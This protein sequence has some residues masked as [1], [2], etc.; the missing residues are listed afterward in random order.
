[1]QKEGKLMYIGYAR[2]ST[3]D[4]SLD[5]QKDALNAARCELIY[6]DVASGTNAE[7]LRMKIALEYMRS[8][9]VRIVLNLDRLGRSLVD[10]VS[11]INRLNAEGKGF[12]CLDQSFDTTT[13]QGKLIFQL[14]AA[15]AEF[16]RNIIRERTMA[17]L[18]AARARGHL[19]GRKPK[20]TLDDVKLAKVLIEDVTI[21]LADIANKFKV[22]VKTLRRSVKRDQSN[23]ST[24]PRSPG[25]KSNGYQ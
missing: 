7:R 25:R 18:A 11:I 23:N 10:L 3:P 20:M 5:L 22:S 1:M 15:L 4:Q 24:Q 8:G 19:G 21:P 13:P 9:D 17:G 14:F 16:E 2:V 6:D 12:K